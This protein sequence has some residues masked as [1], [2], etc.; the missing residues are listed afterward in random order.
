M[1]TGTISGAGG[2]TT[3]SSTDNLSV[4][5][6]ISNIINNGLGLPSTAAGALTPFTYS[7]S[8]ILAPEPA[9]G[10]GGVFLVT[11][12][13]AT[14]VFVDGADQ[15]I[16]VTANGPVSLQ[17]GAAG[18][19]F[20]AGSGLAGAARNVTYT[21]ITPTGTATDNI[22]I[23]GGNNLIQ[24]ATFGTGNYNV[25]TGNGN[26]TVNI[27]LGNSTIN[28]ATG[29]NVIN[30]GSGNN[31]ITS[32]GYDT[33]TGSSVGGGSDTVNVTSGQTSINSGTSS[34]LVND[35]SPNPLNVTLGFGVDTVNVSGAGAA[36]IKGIATTTQATSGTVQGTDTSTGDSL[37]VSGGAATVTA[38]ASNDTIK[39]LSGNNLLLAGTGNDTLVAGAGA[40]TLG[41][42]IGGNASA[43]LVSG[44]GSGTTFQFAFGKSGGAD[45]IT[46]FKSTDILSFTGYGSAP[47]STAIKVGTNTILTLSDSTTITLVGVTPASTQYITK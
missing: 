13:T 27:L 10:S 34:F 20:L 16:D 23:T 47:Q 37:T 36:T 46:G 14:T 42:A 21:N 17:G 30:L 25:A 38:G 35:S 2:G 19:Y 44:T 18:G 22:A 5:M 3:Y 39:A 15:Y 33:I 24:T 28:A 32:V 7:G 11:T 40:D 31:L 9:S 8:G 26:D 1:A 12:P 4:A 45:T 41:G 29:N 6:T 43:L